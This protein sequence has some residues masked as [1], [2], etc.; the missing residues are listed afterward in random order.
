[1]AGTE[2]QRLPSSN[3]PQV[4]PFRPLAYNLTVLTRL[5]A[6]LM[7]AVVIGPMSP[8]G[9]LFRCRLDGQ[10]RDACCCKHAQSGSSSDEHA[11]VHATSRGCCEIM[12]RVASQRE[13]TK[14]DPL[15]GVAQARVLAILPTAESQ[16]PPRIWSPRLTALKTGPPPH[17]GPLFQ[18]RCS[19]LI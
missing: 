16:T 4:A 13:A 15:A 8:G 14:I 5:V 7:T 2:S 12:P 3:T 18:Q 19:L 9:L 11:A 17:I 6:I 10:V 1:M